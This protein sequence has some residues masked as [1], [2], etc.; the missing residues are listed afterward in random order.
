MSYRRWSGLVV[1]GLVWLVAALPAHAQTACTPKT[2]QQ[3][4]QSFSDNS[5]A[6]SITP[7][8]LRNF[9]CSV[10]LGA[11]P[12]SVSTSQLI[13]SPPAS[14]PAVA[15][16][17]V[18]PSIAMLRLNGLTV[19]AT[20]TFQ[21]WI[22]G[23]RTQGDGGEGLFYLNKSDVSSPDNGGTI[24]VDASGHRWYRDY[25][26]SPL[27]P[28][29]FGCLGDGTT[30]DSACLQSTL[31]AGAGNTVWLGRKLYK[32][33][34]GLTI[35]S[36]TRLQGPASAGGIYSPTCTFG[37]K[38]GIAN[39]TM[40]TISGDQSQVQGVCFQS[41][42]N[43]GVNSAGAA[44]KIGVG[45]QTTLDGNQIN[46]PFIGID[47]TGTGGS[48]NANTLVSR[49]VIVNP[50]N[51]GAGIRVGAASTGQNTVDLRIL[52]NTLY[53]DQVGN[54]AVGMLFLDAGGPF[55]QNNDIYQFGVGTKLFPGAN[56][57]V[58]SFFAGNTVLGDSSGQADLI[59]DTASASGVV[60][61]FNTTGSWT[62]SATASNVQVKNTGAGTVN[63]V[64]FTGHNFVL[65]SG[66]GLIGIDLSSGN[67]IKI[68]DSSFCS[69]GGS[70]AIGVKVRSPVRQVQVQG[71]KFTG[72]NQ[73]MEKGVVID[74]G[75]NILTVTGNDFTDTASPLDYV[76]VGTD[77][78]IISAN[79][80]L[81]NSQ[82]LVTSSAATITL[83]L[84]PTVILDDATPIT[85]LGPGWSNRKITLIAKTAG[86]TLNSGGTQ[87]V[88]VTASVPVNTAIALTWN[89]GLNCWV[90]GG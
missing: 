61:W 12:A 52:N 83:P 17:T 5:P 78:M 55:V 89:S 72:C 31:T 32:I 2:S 84:N 13:F 25:G 57:H 34:T 42:A 88:C 19:P 15:A 30:N 79:M 75:A 63:S 27:S 85:G 26:G 66:T 65:H 23:Y 18:L 48:Q 28:L 64:N 16:T 77:T 56:Q 38:A 21:I 82:S 39:L 50:S 45:T 49:N 54:T 73:P 3:L 22:Q 58:T 1:G 24:I 71:N 11:P 33:N 74:S 47:V 10:P 76:P 53:S 44:I 59:I 67:N 68:Q 41:A 90:T 35:S 14:A 9:V 40:L 8:I 51:S 4:L 7:Q 46:N 70:G 86:V 36:P 80:G 29:W 43:F 60:F 81:D 87:G 69:A 37:L 20:G 6:G 62:S